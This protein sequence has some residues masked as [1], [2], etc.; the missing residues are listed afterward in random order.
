M[1]KYQFTEPLSAGEYL[2]VV[3]KPSSAF[4]T[5]YKIPYPNAD[6]YRHVNFY[7]CDDGMTGELQKRV[8]PQAWL[9][10]VNTPAEELGEV[11]YRPTK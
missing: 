6:R 9:G 7:I 8:L 4:L 1:V 10:Y 11:T 2:F 5:V 3:S